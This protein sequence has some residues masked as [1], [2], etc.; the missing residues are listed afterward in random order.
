MI[1]LNNEAMDFNVTYTKKNEKD[2]YMKMVLVKRLLVIPDG[3]VKVNVN[4][5]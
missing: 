1:I 5:L 2:D 4:D 3:Q